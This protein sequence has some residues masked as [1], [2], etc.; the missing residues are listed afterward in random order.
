M[1]FKVGTP[2]LALKMTKVKQFSEKKHGLAEKILE[3]AGEERYSRSRTFDRSRAGLN[4]YSGGMFSSGSD[5]FEYVQKVWAE[6]DEVHRA[7][8]KSHRGLRKDKDVAF[9]LIVKPPAEWANE[10]DAE[11]LE[12]FFKDYH[13]EMTA[14]GI[15][16]D[17][18][19]LIR[20][21]HRDEAGEHEHYV[22][23]LDRTPEGDLGDGLNFWY[24][25]RR[26]GDRNS[27][28]HDML[29]HDIPRAMQARGWDVAECI[30]EDAYD[31]EKAAGMTP[32]ERDAYSAECV[33]KKKSKRHGQSVNEYI[34][35]KRAEEANDAAE[36]AIARAAEAT[37]LAAEAQAAREEVEASINESRELALQWDETIDYLE[38]RYDALNAQTADAQQELADM[39]PKL[40]KCRAE[41]ASMDADKDKAKAEKEKAEAE[42]EAAKKERQRAFEEKLA[43]GE[44]LTQV[45]TN[46]DRREKQLAELDETIAERTAAVQQREAEIARKEAEAERKLKA[47]QDAIETAETVL[48]DAQKEA[49]GAFSFIKSFLETK[50]RKTSPKALNTMLG[51]INGAQKAYAERM[52]TKREK[53][54]AARRSVSIAQPTRRSSEDSYDF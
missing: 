27:S 42:A 23:M 52:E 37:A 45:K 24:K 47:A 51:W 43:M 34:A 22:F 44:S 13:D 50:L 29:N 53:V 10:Q 5:A 40:R 19:V 9:A 14:A 39:E 17:E 6:A 41:I 54:T 46:V 20:A 21:R 1:S 12:R 18:N 28:F 25:A 36:K 8:S 30:D 32:E 7:N 48:N 33:A 4:D 26:K 2:T 11:T 31:A 35:D 3:E 16:K 15:F 49:D 38:D